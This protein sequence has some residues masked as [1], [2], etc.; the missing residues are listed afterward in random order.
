[1]SLEN[2]YKR[3]KYKNGLMFRN[4]FLRNYAALELSQSRLVARK[5]LEKK[6]GNM[7]ILNKRSTCRLSLHP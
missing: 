6:K 3:L 5:H 2:K 4:Y 1:M 7:K